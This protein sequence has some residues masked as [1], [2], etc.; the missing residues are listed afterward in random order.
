MRSSAWHCREM[1]ISLSAPHISSLQIPRAEGSGEPWGHTAVT[2]QGDQLPTPPNTPGQAGCPTGRG[3]KVTLLR[4][5]D[6][7]ESGIPRVR[8]GSA[9]LQSHQPG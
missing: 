4:S 8:W 3:L 2:M 1:L 6:S 5:G 9:A 7:A